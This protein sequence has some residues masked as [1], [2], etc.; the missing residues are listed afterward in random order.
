MCSK[1]LNSIAEC[2]KQGRALIDTR[3]PPCANYFILVVSWQPHE[4]SAGPQQGS[5]VRGKL[6]GGGELS[7]ALREEEAPLSWDFNLPTLSVLKWTFFYDADARGRSFLFL[8]MFLFGN[9]RLLYLMFFV[10]LLDWVLLFLILLAQDTPKSGEHRVILFREGFILF[11]VTN[12]SV[13]SKWIPPTSHRPTLLPSRS[14][15]VVAV[16]AS[17]QVVS[18]WEQWRERLSWSSA[19][20][21]FTEGP[22]IPFWA[23]SPSLQS[24]PSSSSQVLC[25]AHSTPREINGLCFGKHFV[26]FV[27]WLCWFGCL[28]RPCLLQGINHTNLKDYLPQLCPHL[29]VNFLSLVT[30][31]EDSGHLAQSNRDKSKLKWTRANFW[32]NIFPSDFEQ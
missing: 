6:D 7:I 11:N 1:Y 14:H 16:W 18:T 24:S 31:L 30:F 28:Y 21:F 12:N 22:T 15:W 9:T 8:L 19:L 29:R 27:K 2:D 26:G 5:L 17:A 25:L 20:P 32:T 23:T 10:S 4:A 13:S 3:L